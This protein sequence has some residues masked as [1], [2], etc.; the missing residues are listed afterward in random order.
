[1]VMVDKIKDYRDF[2]NALRKLADA[3]EKRRIRSASWSAAF[4]T[5]EVPSKEYK[6]FRA[7]P[8]SEHTITIDWLDLE[9]ADPDVGEQS[10]WKDE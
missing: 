1:M 4:E 3:V 10:S 7:G 5:I 6:Q 8:R 2:A 9:Y